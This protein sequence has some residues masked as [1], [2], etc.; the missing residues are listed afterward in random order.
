MERL[1]RHRPA[2]G[3]PGG[4]GVVRGLPRLEWRGRVCDRCRVQARVLNGLT[5]DDAQFSLPAGDCAVFKATA[6]I[7]QMQAIRAKIFSLWLTQ[8]K[9]QARTGR[10]VEYYLPEFNGQTDSGGFEDWAP[11]P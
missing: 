10:S 2:Q 7:S 6:H 1:Q 3:R 9:R 11:V 8:P 5:D 4:A